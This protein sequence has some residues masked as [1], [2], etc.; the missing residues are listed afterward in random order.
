MAITRPFTVLFGLVTA[1]ATA[2]APD[3]Y[4]HAVL[5]LLLAL[6]LQLVSA[7][8]ASVTYATRVPPVRIFLRPFGN[9]AVQERYYSYM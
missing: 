8:V 6:P 9:A 4:D 2:V 3:I 1:C 7:L 5:C